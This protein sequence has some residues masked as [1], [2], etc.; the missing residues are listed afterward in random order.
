M[1][2]FSFAARL[3]LVGAVV[4][5]LGAFAPARV[6]A[7]EN[8]SMAEI[9]EVGII[10][11]GICTDAPPEDG[12]ADSC[13]CRATGDCT[14]DHILQLFVNLANFTLGISGSVLLFVFTYGG[15]KWLMS[16]GDAKWVEAGKAAMTGGIV[17]IVIIFG[18]YV[19]INVIV[20]GLKTGAVGSGTLESTL[21]TAPEGGDAADVGDAPFS[22]SE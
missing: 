10:F 8:S 6:F 3:A 17:G 22:T 5:G 14:L 19:A 16:R 12:G 9:E 7:A 4:M 18:A 15:F 11:A 1:A 20:S 2:R 21:E 13:A